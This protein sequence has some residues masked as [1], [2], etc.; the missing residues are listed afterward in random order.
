MKRL[1]PFLLLL[2]IVPTIHYFLLKPVWE[3][4]LGPDDWGLL[5]AYKSLIGDSNPFL[6]IA[7]VWHVRG[8]YTTYQVYYIGLLEKTF[9]LDYLAF[10]TINILFKTLATLSVYFLVNT[11]FKRKSLAFLTTLLFAISYTS[12]GTFKFVV[13]GADYLALAL[14]NVFLVTYYY[15]IKRFRYSMFLSPLLLVSLLLSPP[16]IYPVLALIPI[17]EICLVFFSKNRV[18]SIG[19]GLCRLILVFAPLLALA[20]LDRGAVNTHFVYLGYLYQRLSEG[21]W[22]LFVNSLSGLGIF[23][24][25]FNGFIAFFGN[26]GVSFTQYFISVLPRYL[27]FLF[28]ISAIA[29]ILISQ[30]PG[31]FFKKLFITHL[32]IIIIFFF[33]INHNSLDYDYLVFTVQLLGVFI[34]ELGLFAWLE[35]KGGSQRSDSLLVPI[36]LGVGFSF[37]FLFFTWIIAYGQVYKGIHNYLVIPSMGLSLFVSAIFLLIYQKIGVKRRTMSYL[38]ISLLILAFFITSKNEINSYFINELIGWKASDQRLVQENLLRQ[39]KGLLEEPAL[40]FFDLSDERSQFRFYEVSALSTFINWTN[41]HL[42]TNK[43]SSCRSV[44]Y[45]FEKERLL[46]LVHKRGNSI[47]LKAN[48]YCISNG[49]AHFQNME[50]DLEHFYAY[51]IRD[52]QFIDEK[53]EI[54]EY[55]LKENK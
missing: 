22:H 34:L 36:S 48:A 4:G 18:V 28:P 23:F 11:I 37:I 16:R 12:T 29:S 35:W 31:T 24:L 38:V 1:S 42:G 7:K 40:F 21:K 39:V 26:Q 10:Q 27:L 2:I 41:Y 44:F 6:Q 33:L 45:H 51:K 54:V 50:F 52:K 14:M 15:S 19:R 8:M 17:T 30:T 9:G 20:L 49:V 47:K 32:I 5:Y 46:E 43:N 55:L 53:N 25:P 13:Q 3:N